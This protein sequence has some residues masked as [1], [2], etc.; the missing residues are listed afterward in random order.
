MKIRSITCFV[1][2]GWPLD[3]H[4]LEYA[5]GFNRAARDAFVESGYEVQTTRLACVPFSSLLYGKDAFEGIEFS[6]ALE[7]AAL[8]LGFDYVSIGPALPGH[9]ESLRVIPDILENTSTVFASGVISDPMK[10]ISLEAVWG[11]ANVIKRNAQISSDGFA[12][13]RFAA[14]ASVEP[15]APFFPAAYHHG[16][17]LAFA[18]A[19]EAADLAVEAVRQGKSFKEIRRNLI[20]SIESNAAALSQIGG[21]LAERYQIDFAGLDFSL[22]PF[23]DPDFS[24]GT[25]LEELTGMSLGSPGSLTGVGFLTDVIDHARFKKVGFCGVMLPVLE[26]I[27]LARR[28]AEGRLRLTDLLLYSAVC[29]TGLD[30]IPLP[31]DMSSEQIAAI[32]LDLGVLSL[33]L[34]KPLTARLMPI[35][36]KKAGDETGFDFPYFANSRVMSVDWQFGKRLFRSDAWFPLT[37]SQG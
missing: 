20:A 27:V 3:L 31:G 7:K 33:R 22:A 23:P 32:L 11:C 24:I 2:P 18:L 21:R 13:L 36:G 10:G 16:G 34:N 8:E 14:L 29:G 1:D 15:K 9:P 19:L 17:E 6:I 35:P 28:V 12:N 25:A 26:D 37:S 4:G 30:T 5:G